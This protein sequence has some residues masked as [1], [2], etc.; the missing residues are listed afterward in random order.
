MERTTI[1]SLH[2]KAANAES[3][4][5]ACSGAALQRAALYCR[6]EH[7]YRVPNS[8]ISLSL[9]YKTL[10]FKNNRKN[11][12]AAKFPLNH[13]F[14][15]IKEISRLNA[16]VNQSLMYAS[17]TAPS[18]QETYPGRLYPLRLLLDSS[19]DSSSYRGATSPT[20]PPSPPNSHKT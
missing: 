7:K 14:S 1:F 17:Q 19:S 3:L 2:A 13:L 12:N 16:H 15:E 11:K 6:T 8:Q 20:P 10:F 4:P 18:L 5:A 9:K